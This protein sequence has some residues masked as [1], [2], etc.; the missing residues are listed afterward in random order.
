MRKLIDE[1]LQPKVVSLFGEPLEKLDAFDIGVDSA[2]LKGKP[3]L[4]CFWDMQQRPS[5]HCISQ[6]GEQAQQLRER[7]VAVIAVQA[8]KT[9]RN[10]LDEWVRKN[11]IPFPVGMIQGDEQKTHFAWGIMSLPWLVLTDRQHIVRA[12][13][14]GIGALEK[15]LAVQHLR[16]PVNI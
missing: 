6:L 9:D 13:G 11:G 14:F 16:P 8:S 2:K 5:R 3:I 4:V 10:T 12:Q 1:S 7:G 15:K